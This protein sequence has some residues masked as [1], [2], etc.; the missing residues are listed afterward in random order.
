MGKSRGGTRVIITALG[1]KVYGTIDDLKVRPYV[2]VGI[3]QEAY[4][5]PKKSETATGDPTVSDKSTVGDAALAAEF[6]T[7]TEPER[8]W[9]RSTVDANLGNKAT[10][11]GLADKLRHEMFVEG[12]KVARALGLIGLAMENSFREKI[13]SN[14]P[15]PNAPSTIAAKG[16]KDK[17]LINTGQFVNSVASEVHDH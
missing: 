11:L 4:A 5:E 14:I 7:D 16:G 2:K 1:K 10:W 3:L 8:S 13:R 17:T 12:M 9:M 6:G 15:P